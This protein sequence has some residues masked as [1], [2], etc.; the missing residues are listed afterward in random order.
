MNELSLYCIYDDGNAITNC[1]ME[2]KTQVIDISVGFKSKTRFNIKYNG[3]ENNEIITIDDVESITITHI[4][5]QSI[6]SIIKTLKERICNVVAKRTD[7][8]NNLKKDRNK[9]LEKIDN[10][11]LTQ[12]EIISLRKDIELISD[13]I[14]NHNLE[15]N[16]IKN[17]VQNGEME[18][19]DETTEYNITLYRNKIQHINGIPGQQG[20]ISFLLISKKEIDKIIEPTKSIIKNKRKI[21][22]SCRDFV[23]EKI[24]N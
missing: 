9:F 15:I 22:I 7:E 18:I 13:Q 6:E 12:E 24:L 10:N 23:N 14:R 19:G 20:R 4:H 5:T 21:K 3:F 11:D 1:I 8:I 2:I 16:K 17:D